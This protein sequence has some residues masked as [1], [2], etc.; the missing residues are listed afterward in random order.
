MNKCFIALGG[1]GCNLLKEFE[2]RNTPNDNYKF[3][4]MDSD[5]ANGNNEDQRYILTNQRYGCAARIVGKDEIKSLIYNGEMPDIID[6]FFMAE[7]FELIFVTTSFGGFGS[8]IVFELSDY[9]GVKVKKYRRVNDVTT[10]FRI[11]VVAFTINDF[12]MFQSF[13]KSVRTQFE[14]NEIQFINE[15]R[16]KESRNNAWYLNKSN[17]IPCV[18][19]FVPY[20]K[21][22]S[23]IYD[24]IGKDDDELE[25]LDIKKQFYYSP[26]VSRRNKDVFISYS[27]KNQN[28]ADMLVETANEKGISCWIA[29]KSIDAGSYAKQIVQGIREAKVFVAIVS[30]DST[31]S[32][33]VKN[34]LG[35]ATEHIKDGL[36]I[37]PFKIDDSQLDDECRYYLGRQEFY[38]ANKPPIQEK[39]NDFIESIKKVLEV[40]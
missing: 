2:T 8:A 7:D 28:I 38:F 29:T 15:F 16:E 3:I 27:S 5:V 11:K 24:C 40:M 35:I 36:V 23:D 10:D 21:K 39:I 31:S 33:H 19:L 1:L 14:T 6:P 18:Q 22:H 4:Y 12:P 17:C 26:K 9:Y 32:V 13:P 37:M 25:R 20:V 30:S 34:E